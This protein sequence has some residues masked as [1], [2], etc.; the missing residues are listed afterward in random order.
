MTAAATGRPQPGHYVRAAQ[1]RAGDVVR[2][3]LPAELTSAREARAVVRR[4][5]AE[6]GISDSDGDAE[7]LTS[8]V[9][10]N[11]AEHAGGP[12]RLSLRRDPEHRSGIR[13][14][15]TDTSPAVPKPREAG[16]GEERGRG[17]S[18]VSALASDSGVRASEAGKTTWFTLALG[19]RIQHTG[20]QPG[21]QPGPEPA[22]HAEFEAG[23]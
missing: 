6:W 14:E 23:A 16:R 1:E 12:I 2:A 9:V 10:A 20:P 15:V 21:P 3:D 4:A 17:L 11:A 5:L 18:I 19:D 22:R 7:L 8:E 13:C